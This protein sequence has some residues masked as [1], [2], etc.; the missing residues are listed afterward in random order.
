MIS[1]QFIEKIGIFCR[2]ISLDQLMTD[3]RTKDA[4]LRNISV[5]KEGDYREALKDKILLHRKYHLHTE[6][7]NPL[8]TSS[9]TVYRMI[10]N[11]PPDL[12]REAIHF[13]EEL[14]RRKKKPAARKFSLGWAG[15]LSHLK[16]STTSVELQHAAREWRD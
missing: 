11:L 3:E 6:T 15:G 8:M 5:T 1:V 4:I 2:G 12:K 7:G 16:D 13:I 14:A 10:D 9:R